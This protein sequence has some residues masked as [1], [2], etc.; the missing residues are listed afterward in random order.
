MYETQFLPAKAQAIASFAASYSRL[1][2]STNS[3]VGTTALTA[4]MP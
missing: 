1:S 3:A 4:P 2:L